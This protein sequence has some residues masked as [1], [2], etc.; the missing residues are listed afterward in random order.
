MNKYL[1]GSTALLFGVC[2]ALGW[3]LKGQI[4]DN[5]KLHAKLATVSNEL[6]AERLAAKLDEQSSD[7]H[8]QRNL[9]QGKP[10]DHR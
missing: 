1:I 4:Q 5:G 9:L 7:P 2:A 3:G 10:A 8:F 6:E